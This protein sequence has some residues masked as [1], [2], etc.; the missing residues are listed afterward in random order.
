ME[1]A[2]EWITQLE[3]RTIEIYIE[4]EEQKEKTEVS[5]T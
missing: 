1:K 2:E 5:K 4:S 3:D